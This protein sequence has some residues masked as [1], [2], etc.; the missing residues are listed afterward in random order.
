MCVCVCLCVYICVCVSRAFMCVLC[1][2]VCVCVYVCLYILSGMRT[3]Q[4]RRCREIDNTIRQSDWQRFQSRRKQTLPAILH[5]SCMCLCITMCVYVYMCVYVSICIML[6]MRTANISY[7]L[8]CF[9]CIRLVGCSY[10]LPHYIH[11][12]THTHI[13]THTHTYTH[14]QTLTTHTHTHTTTTQQQQ[15]GD[16]GLNEVMAVAT[17][18]GHSTLVVFKLISDI[19]WM[20]KWGS[21]WKIVRKVCS[22]DALNDVLYLLVECPFPVSNRD[23]VV[24]R[25]KYAHPTNDTYSVLFRTG[26]HPKYPPAKK[27]IIRAATLGIFGY[28]VVNKSTTKKS[29]NSIPYDQ[30]T[31]RKSGVVTELRVRV[32][33]DGKGYLP[34]RLVNWGAPRVMDKWAVNLQNA[35][36]KH[37]MNIEKEM[38]MSESSSE[39]SITRHS[40]TTDSD[41]DS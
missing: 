12:Q 7:S 13:H 14:T 34:K 41:S 33:F 15:Y 32:C 19:K 18:Y 24:F 16:T 25:T 1:V 22:V 30:K 31:N 38:S 11:T 39:S 2:C 10:C 5:E 9:H 20:L 37:G 3:I 40:A 26:K 21:N 35:C 17:I 23:F 27:R 6:D 36:D 4:W 28:L 8:A 29:S